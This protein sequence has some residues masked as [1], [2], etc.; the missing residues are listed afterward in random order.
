MKTIHAISIILML[1]VAPISAYG[2]EDSSGKTIT[3]G[4]IEE[5]FLADR[6]VKFSGLKAPNTNL[7]K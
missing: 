1:A 4:K 6:R 2:A 5:G 3:F 7:H